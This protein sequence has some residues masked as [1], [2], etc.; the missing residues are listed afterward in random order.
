M[1]SR[2]APKSTFAM[3]FMQTLD[4]LSPEEKAIMEFVMMKARDSGTP[5]LSLFTP[6][7]LLSLAKEC[8]FKEA[9]YVSGEDIYQ[10]YFSQRTDGLRAGKAEAF[11]IATT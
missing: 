5:F 2:L 1:I 3:T 6:T 10:A 9:K 7:Q 4:L 8:G 11:L